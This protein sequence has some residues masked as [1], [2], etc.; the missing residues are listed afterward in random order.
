M[1]VV[2]IKD[3]SENVSTAYGVATTISGVTYQRFGP[4]IFDNTRPVCLV[5]AQSSLTVGE[6]ST[7]TVSCTDLN[8]GI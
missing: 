8:S 6:T 2:R 1:F 4:Y 3:T 5:N 7:F